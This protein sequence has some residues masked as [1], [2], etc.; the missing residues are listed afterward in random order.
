MV[1]IGFLNILFDKVFLVTLVVGIT[2]FATI[3]TLGLPVIERDGLGAR[4]NSVAKRR[5]EFCGPGITP[6]STPSAAASGSGSNLMKSTLERFKLTNMLESE[7]SKEKLA[8]AGYRGPAPMIAFMFF[9]FVMPPVVFVVMLFYLF[10]VTHFHYGTMEKI[11]AAFAG[12]LFGYYLPDLFVSN[13]ISRRQQSIMRAF[14]DALDTMLIYVNPVC[15]SRAVSPRQRK[16][17]M[18]EV[19]LTTAELSITR[20]RQASTIWPTLR[21]HPACGRWRSRSTRLRNT[22]RPWARRCALPQPK[23][24]KCAWRRPNARPHRYPPSSPCR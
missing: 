18:A 13:A 16:S 1:D 3:V 4:L 6:P 12:A 23:T 15:R 17:A 20:R 7:N 21:S 10:V 9:R 2:A 22:V 24:A 5:E 11:C 19:G 8:S 14:P